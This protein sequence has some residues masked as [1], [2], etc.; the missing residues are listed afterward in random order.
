MKKLVII[1]AYNEQNN[2]I[3]VINDLKMN[4]PDF[5]Y[6][7]INDGST[8]ETM[9]LCAENSLNVINLPVNL[10]IGACVQTG[11]KY[12]LKKGYK[13]AVQF[14]GDG[15]HKAEYLGKMYKE[16]I[17]TDSDMVIGSRYL[18]KNGFQSTVFRRM[19]I[20]IL[21]KLIKVLYKQEI[22]DVTS[23]LRMVNKRL[24]TEFSNY[25]PYDYPE[26]ETV[27][28]CMRKKFKITEVAVTM[29]ARNEGKSSI[30]KIQS[31]Y[32]MVKVSF[33]IIIDYFKK[34]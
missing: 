16:M 30:N 22:K 7:I 21:S 31:I 29:R 18:Y 15:Q 28:F 26:P 23:G 33:S 20:K 8:D 9:T 25:Y 34:T 3:N 24:V 32:Y 17:E 10:G 12:A 6:V 11:Y 1:P 5:D 19:G 14:D 4:A 13:I 2:L 27:A